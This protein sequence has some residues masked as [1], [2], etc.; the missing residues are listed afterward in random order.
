MRPER[1]GFGVPPAFH[2]FQITEDSSELEVEYLERSQGKAVLVDLGGDKL[3]TTI[4]FTKSSL[5]RE[6]EGHCRPV[7]GSPFLL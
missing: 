5:P 4:N 1:K 3:Q 6:P 2:I 7:S